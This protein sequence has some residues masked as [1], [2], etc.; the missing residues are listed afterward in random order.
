MSDPMLTVTVQDA[1]PASPT[2]PVADPANKAAPQ[3][4]STPSF[5]PASIA[6]GS[7]LPKRLQ[8]PEVYAKLTPTGTK[9]ENLVDGYLSAT[10]KL[11]QLEG[12]TAVPGKDAKP[13][14]IEAF[15]KS[16]GRPDAPAGYQFDRSGEF[17]KVP[18][19]PGLDEFTADL[20]HRHNLPKDV[21]ESLWKENAKKSLELLAQIK[22]QREANA[23][24]GIK[25]LEKLWGRDMP[26]RK[27][28]F[29]GV[30]KS[31]LGERLTKA[32]LGTDLANDAEFIDKMASLK[33]YLS[34]A[35]TI[36]GGPAGAGEKS[37]A[38][39]IFGG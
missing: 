32:F 38:D 23:D 11:A 25:D 24:Q 1:P 13:E 34:N 6:F 7:Q 35:R 9:L 2:A 5:D 10:E 37:L 33:S 30:F 18:K 3:G 16:M 27:T 17:E 4:E 39:R 28:E 14:E 15:W 21:A 29:D 36:P 20:F 8:T 31:F 19:L 12:R 22:T 26:Q